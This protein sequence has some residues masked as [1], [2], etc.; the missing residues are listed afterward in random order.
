MR[1]MQLRID[2]F[3]SFLHFPDVPIRNFTQRKGIIVFF[4]SS[5]HKLLLLLIT[6]RSLIPICNLNNC[7][8]VDITGLVKFRQKI[9]TQE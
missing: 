4:L 1:D 2:N 5:V 3:T 7:L 6:K 9:Y 8:R